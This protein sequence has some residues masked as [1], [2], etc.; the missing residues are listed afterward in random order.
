MLSGARDPALSDTRIPRAQ[1]LA[2]R[3]GARDWPV[4]SRARSFRRCLVS[5]A[6]SFGSKPIRRPAFRLSRSSGCPIARST[7]HASACA[8]IIKSGFGF[9]P[10]R[11]LVNLAP[12]DVCKE[13]PGFDLP[14]ALALLALA[15][16]G[17]SPRTEL[18]EEAKKILQV[19][20]LNNPA[21]WGDAVH[22]HC[23]KHDRAAR[24][25]Y[26]E[27][28]ASVR[29]HKPRAYRGER[30]AAG[31]GL[32]YH[33]FLLVGEIWERGADRSHVCAHRRAR[34]AATRIGRVVAPLGRQHVVEGRVVSVTKGVVEASNESVDGGGSENGGLIQHGLSPDAEDG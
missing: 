33:S 31:H 19:P 21:I 28:S 32:D 2:A 27:E 13:G 15:F 22:V 25:L 14:I 10:G 20:R 17:L 5:T 24:R 7:N 1:E 26:A 9:P 12:A 3:S 11:L 18:P 8:A 16:R 4:C 34:V 29:S 30:A 23:A 6:M